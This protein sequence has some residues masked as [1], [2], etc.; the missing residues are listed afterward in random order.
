MAPFQMYQQLEA[1]RDA[2]ADRLIS[3]KSTRDP[4]MHE[5]LQ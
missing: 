3:G 2:E 4:S 5:V 1:L